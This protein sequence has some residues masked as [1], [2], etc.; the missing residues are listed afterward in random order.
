MR[1]QKEK[2]EDIDYLYASARLRCLERDLLNREKMDR[3]IEAKTMEDVAKVLAESNYPELAPQTLAEV[4]QMLSEA[5]LETFKLLDSMAPDPRLIDVFKVKF[6]Y[7][8]IKTIL[9]GEQGESGGYRELL[10]PCGRVPAAALQDAMREGSYSDLPK[11]MRKAIEEARETLARTADPQLTDC[12]LDIACYTEMLAIAKETG[13]AFLVGYVKLLIDSINLRTAIRV[14]RMGKGFD[15]LRASL[16]EGGDI[17]V[18]RLYGDITPDLLDAV[19]HGKELAEAAAIGAAVLR[20]EAGLAKVDL[21]ADDALTH[22]LQNAKYVAFGEQPL[23]AY[24]AAKEN[25]ITAI[26]TIMS[27]RFAQLAPETIRERL[28]EAYV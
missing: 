7:H 23:V 11:P 16:I 22:Y 5:R 17:A 1:L 27:G 18:S 14:K 15:F 4:E 25:E 10:S 3:M 13:S 9:K 26:R 6:D 21:A 19:Y 24:M 2:I 12:I 8:N 20:N 28:R